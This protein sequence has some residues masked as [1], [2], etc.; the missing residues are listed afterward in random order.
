MAL[1]VVKPFREIKTMKNTEKPINIKV[2]NKIISFTEI[3]ASDYINSK[4]RVDAEMTRLIL[5]EHIVFS[6]QRKARQGTFHIYNNDTGLWYGISET[7]K[8]FEDI[9]GLL[10]DKVVAPIREYFQAKCDVSDNDN[11]KKYFKAQIAACDKKKLALQTPANKHGII[12]YLKGNEKPPE[13]FNSQ[14][15]RTHFI[16]GSYNE[17][18][19]SLDP[20]S[21]DNWHTLSTN[22][23]FPSEDADCPQ[24]KNL[25]F[26]LVLSEN[27]F[28]SEENKEL[29]SD[30]L[31]ILS[32]YITGST[33]NFGVVFMGS[34]NNSKSLP[35]EVLTKV[36]G[37]YGA[38]SSPVLLTG[39][40]EQNLY[41]NELP[42]KRLAVLG[43]L[44]AKQAIDN[45]WKG[46]VSKGEDAQTRGHF[47]SPNSWRKDYTIVAF[48]NDGI[49]VKED[50]PGLLDRL[51]IFPFL[52]KFSTEGRSPSVYE[53]W[54]NTYLSETEGI[55]RM[56]ID[57]R[58]CFLHQ[59]H[60]WSKTLISY[61]NRV[62]KIS[63]D[64][65]DVRQ[66]FY[67]QDDYVIDPTGKVL[68]SEVYDKFEK[69]AEDCEKKFHTSKN[70]FGKKLPTGVYSKP[71]TDN[72]KYIYGIGHNTQL[73]E[74]QDADIFR[75][76]ESKT[77]EHN[78][79]GKVIPLKRN[80]EILHGG[81]KPGQALDSMES[82]P[83][84]QSN[85]EGKDFSKTLADGL[86]TGRYE[87]FSTKMSS[88]RRRDSELMTQMIA[89]DKR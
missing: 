77:S 1:L 40:R 62:L 13:V 11:D 63:F 68:F 16:D 20:H 45:V 48:V 25:L 59:P 49:K 54:I 84:I 21:P 85:D 44:D 2:H 43:D 86:E 69:W 41:W 33:P 82:R 15:H 57:A 70:T 4:E 79:N 56:L 10:S 37:D 14:T 50:S 39:N 18:T 58:Q 66:W 89:S 67:E 23:P 36:L 27:G 22:K 26:N 83:A 47:E 9:Q 3:E 61:K 74:N 65:T 80:Q 52:H 55:L 78:R 53:G 8:T 87:T 30:L 76:S 51:V 46:L 24:F 28:S 81:N 7:D 72:K 5:G 64:L 38:M 31:Y 12:G 88:R 29:K 42:G 34:G 73:K 17:I 35:H 60:R 6:K 75:L 19:N 71:G 32:T